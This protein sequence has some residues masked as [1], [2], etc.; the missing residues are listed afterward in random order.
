[1]MR[2][3][4]LPDG[5]HSP[6]L[7]CFS[8]QDSWDGWRS[9]VFPGAFLLLLLLFNRLLSSSSSGLISLGIF[10][11]AGQQLFPG[12][13]APSCLWAT[14]TLVPG[15]CP[16]WWVFCPRP[17]PHAVSSPSRKS[18]RRFYFS[19]FFLRLSR[20]SRSSSRSRTRPTWSAAWS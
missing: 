8:C 2:C 3:C 16:T 14:S 19:D 20:K 11:L 5:R 4:C 13:L 15:P 7:F 6:G 18:W 12:S 17:P 1:M 10:C 9:A